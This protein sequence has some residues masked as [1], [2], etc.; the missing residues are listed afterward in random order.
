[1][2]RA[3]LDDLGNPLNYSTLS[4]IE[5]MFSILRW[6]A[7][8]GASR[9]HWGSDIDVYDAHTQKPEMVKLVPSECI[10]NGPAAPMHEWLDSLISQNAAFGFY[11]PYNTDL[12]GV[13]P[14][15]WHLSYSP[16]SRRI[17]EQY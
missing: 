7:A 15:R 11:R 3:L 2:E 16:V 8:P 14:E 6:S 9:H 10:E 12:G 17:S 5:I 1:G 13:S 4:P